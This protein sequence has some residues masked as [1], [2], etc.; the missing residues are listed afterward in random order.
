MRSVERVPLL[1]RGARHRHRDRRSGAA[2]A[3]LCVRGG[4]DRL[5]D[6]LDAEQIRNKITRAASHEIIE[7]ATDPL[8]ATGWINNGIV[9][10][11]DDVSSRR[12]SSRSATSRRI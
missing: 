9:T 6:R 8:V 12:S 10:D 5:R 3:D 11:A 4:P 7:A 1:R 2:I